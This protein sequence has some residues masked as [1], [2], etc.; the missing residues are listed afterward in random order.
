EGY[1]VIEE[2]DG[3]DTVKK[4]YIY[5]SWIDE[6]LRMDI[7]ENGT[8]SPYYFHHNLI[9]SI[10]GITDNTGNIVELVEYD[11]YGKPYFL[12]STG[13]PDNP[14]EITVTSTIGN[15]YLFQGREYDPETGLYYFRARYYDPILSRFLSPDP[16]GYVDSMN[17]YQA[18][19]D[20]PLNFVDPLGELIIL[21]G[22]DPVG[23]FELLK[24][25]FRKLGIRNIDDILTYKKDSHGRYYIELIGGKGA[26]KKSVK[27]SLEEL[28]V[29]N[30]YKT[31]IDRFT[32]QL[33]QYPALYKM[34]LEELFE[35]M[36][37]DRERK[38][39]EFRTGADVKI[40]GFD[41]KVRSFGGGVTIEPHESSTG[42]I[43]VVVDTENYS[44]YLIDFTPTGEKLWLDISTIIAHEFG[45][46]LASQLGF[47]GEK[48]IIFGLFKKEVDP[49]FYELALMMENQYRLRRGQK[50]LR[51]FH[52]PSFYAMNIKEIW[53]VKGGKF[54][55]IEEIGK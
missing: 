21:S 32:V 12:R 9:G 50:W 49:M 18:F 24:E 15:N 30:A 2:R 1:R 55:K 3:S 42:N 36:I 31:W 10:T 35:M 46:A 52:K 41:K 13:N 6:L 4:Q 38:P 37:L 23:D 25:V 54:I 47:V 48:S 27:N 17:L 22:Q 16:L 44:K 51:V 29:Y 34:T 53:K 11:P 45:H 8:A 28:G 33:K 14:Y 19:N 40:D 20:N 39:I 43:E 26:L 7:F 5:G